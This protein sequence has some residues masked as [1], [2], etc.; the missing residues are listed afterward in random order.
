MSSSSFLLTSGRPHLPREPPRWLPKD[1]LGLLHFQPTLRRWRRRR[2]GTIPH[3]DPFPQAG[4]SDPRSRARVS[5]RGDGRIVGGDELVLVCVGGR[6][7]SRRDSDLAE[8]VTD[9]A[10]DG[11]FAEKQ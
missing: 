9:V 3:T 4:Y 6:G 11:L 10:V 8:D 7:G 2:F 1:D 5:P